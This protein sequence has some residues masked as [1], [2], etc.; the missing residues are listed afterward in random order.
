MRKTL[1]ALTAFIML[2]A[3]AS[4]VMAQVY[5]S[6]PVFRT[7]SPFHCEAVFKGGD[8]AQN[9]WV[10]SVNPTEIISKC[11]NQGGNADNSNSHIFLPGDTVLTGVQFGNTFKIVKNGKTSGDVEF[12]DAD[13]LAALAAVGVILD[14]CPNPN[15]SRIFMITK[16]TNATANI[17]ATQDSNN[18][19]VPANPNSCDPAVNG[20]PAGCTQNECYSFN[21]C[22]KPNPTA[23]I[24]ETFNCTC[25][26]HFDKGVLYG[27]GPNC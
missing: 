18:L 21:P 2:V 19:C 7:N 3:M 1:V 27:P 26:Q 24:S 8:N 9:R 25:Q 17:L 10:C 11:V 22:T 5:F 4:P 23:F 13:I 16:T 14:P 6:K 20:V 15:F 12:K